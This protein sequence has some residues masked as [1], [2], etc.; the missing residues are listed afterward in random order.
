MPTRVQLRQKTDPSTGKQHSSMITPVKIGY[1]KRSNSNENGDQQHNV[2]VGSNVTF[3]ITTSKQWTEDAT[4][5]LVT[6]VLPSGY[7]FVSVSPSKRELLEQS[8]YGPSEL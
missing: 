5:V 7:T 2:N 1:P 4:G 8:P 3:T 6:D